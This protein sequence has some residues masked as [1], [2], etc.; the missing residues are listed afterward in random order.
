MNDEDRVGFLI[1]A[2]VCQFM[3]FPFQL[4]FTLKAHSGFSSR[5]PSNHALVCKAKDTLLFALLVSKAPN[6]NGQEASAKS[7]EVSSSI[8][9]FSRESSG[10]RAGTSGTSHFTHWIR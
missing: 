4:P 9:V 10:K 7:A 2:H 6:L 8:F 5:K 1:V 3:Y